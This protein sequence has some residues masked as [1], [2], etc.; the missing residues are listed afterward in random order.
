MFRAA[1]L[2]GGLSEPSVSNST[3]VPRR[4]IN[5]IRSGIAQAMDADLSVGQFLLLT[6]AGRRCALPLSA[7]AEILRP[8]QLESLAGVPSFVL[9]AAIVRGHVAPV[10]DLAPLLGAGPG[11]NR[12]WI[13]LRREQGPA[14]LSVDSVEGV[15]DLPTQGQ[16]LPTLL[17]SGESPVGALR[18]S[19]AALLA[20]LESGRLIPEAVWARLRSS[21]DAVA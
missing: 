12:R 7:V 20:V 1:W 8:L 14:L 6:S 5:L 11:S 3:I 16:T 21:T 18:V 4:P 15:F 10:A 17:E 13:S 19:D 2:L 9:G